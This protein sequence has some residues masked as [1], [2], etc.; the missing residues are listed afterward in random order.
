MGRRLAAVLPEFVKKPLNT[1]KEHVERIC[2]R[3][4]GRFCPLCG[5]S[6]SKFRQH[7]IVPR[8]DARCTRCGALE[9]H[10]LLWLYLINN[11][12]LFDFRRQIQADV[13]RGTR[14]LL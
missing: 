9:R 14:A 3:G 6:S 5:K 1:V 8:E 7:G 13:A 11:T 2:H 10:R 4:V 12:D